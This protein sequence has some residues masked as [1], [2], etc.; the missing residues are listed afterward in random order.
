MDGG[1]EG[2]A[3]IVRGFAAVCRI[4]DSKGNFLQA[5]NRGEVRGNSPSFN[6]VKLPIQAL[7]EGRGHAQITATIKRTQDPDKHFKEKLQI[8]IVI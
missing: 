1:R 4:E 5:F 2:P 8:S 6:G 3:R 7:K